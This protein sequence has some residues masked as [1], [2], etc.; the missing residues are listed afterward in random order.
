MGAHARRGIETALT[1]A[2]AGGRSSATAATGVG[3]AQYLLARRPSLGAARF[4]PH[5]TTLLHLAV[6]HD[7]AAFVELA[8]AHGIDPEVRGTSFG[9]TALGWA[10]HFGRADLARRL[11]QVT[12]TR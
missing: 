3:V 10:E 11:M 1:R 4:E 8:L 6:E 2:R 5:A 9:A 12:V 7:S